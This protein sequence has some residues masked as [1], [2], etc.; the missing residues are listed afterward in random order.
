MN[1]RLRAL[2]VQIALDYFNEG[3]YQECYEALERVWRMSGAPDRGLY[4]GIIQIA[5]A[6]E[7]LL[8]GN[9]RGA[10]SLF[11]TGAALIEPFA[12][13]RHGIAVGQLHQATDAC[14][15]ELLRLGEARVGE[16]DR[17][18]LPRIAFTRVQL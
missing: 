8:G 16:F 11:E 3:R 12:P 13:E 18:K 2:Q 14:L 9:W 10:V 1:E 4:Q 17:A 15:R 6:C 5:G 7:K